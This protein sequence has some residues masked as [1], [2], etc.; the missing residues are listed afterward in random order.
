MKNPLRCRRAKQ[1]Q[2]KNRFEKEK[3]INFNI[4]M[5]DKTS[6]KNMINRFMFLICKFARYLHI[7]GGT[8]M[9]MMGYSIPFKAKNEAQSK[10]KETKTV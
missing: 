7:C 10:Q 3:T 5:M 2:Q 1:Q 6:R 9:W 8:Y 4:F